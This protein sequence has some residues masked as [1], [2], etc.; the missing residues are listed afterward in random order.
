MSY[1]WAHF[2][3]RFLRYAWTAYS[4][5]SNF[6]GS[7]VYVRLGVT[8]HLHFWKNDQGLL[9]ATVVTQGETDDE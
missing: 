6:V 2:P 1:V 8:C 5:H 3:D 7:K 4:A 9:C